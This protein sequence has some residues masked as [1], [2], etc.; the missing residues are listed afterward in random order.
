MREKNEKKLGL[1]LVLHLQIRMTKFYISCCT[2]NWLERLLFTKW[3]F[4]YFYKGL[5]FQSIL[6]RILKLIQ[7]LGCCLMIFC[8]KIFLVK[9][10]FSI[11]IF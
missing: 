4:T 7:D 2:L 11:C 5:I 9:R 3:W 10:I 6:M 8:L 1:V